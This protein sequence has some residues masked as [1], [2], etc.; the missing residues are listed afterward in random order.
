MYLTNNICSS[1]ITLRKI[2][3]KSYGYDKIYMGKDLIEDKLYQL[4]DQ[5]NKR[6]TNHRDFY[7][8]LLNNIHLLDN[9]NG[10][11]CKIPFVCNLN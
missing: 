10:R 5:F 7:Y 6:K 3:V 11:T 2:N 1:N 8:E 4:I 9:G